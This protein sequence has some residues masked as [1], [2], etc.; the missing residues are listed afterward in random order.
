MT[1][2]ELKPRCG[3]CGGVYVNHMPRREAAP[4]CRKGG[5]YRPGT[6]EEL[7][8]F[9]R[10]EFPNGVEP[11]ATIH[12]DNPDEMARARAALNP[13]ALARDL[14]P[15]GGGIDAITAALRG[16]VL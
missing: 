16:E 2:T 11:I 8:A 10:A 13:E 5:V 4:I 15:H 3:N 14:G 6:E 12:F 1:G 9:Y 7:D